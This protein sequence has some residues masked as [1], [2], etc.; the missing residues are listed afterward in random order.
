VG[1]ANSRIRS[2]DALA[3]RSRRPNTSIRRSLSSIFR[4]I[5]SASGRTATVAAEV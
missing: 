4:S 1:N 5:S 3:A 2:V